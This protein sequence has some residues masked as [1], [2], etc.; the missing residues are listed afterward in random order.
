MGLSSVGWQRELQ[1]HLLL[2]TSSLTAAG[3]EAA[4]AEQELAAASDLNLQSNADREKSLRLRETG[5]ALRARADEDEVSAAAD[6]GRAV[7]LH[8]MAVS[9]EDQAAD[10]L[11]LAAVQDGIAKRSVA[12]GVEQSEG[13]MSKGMRAQVD[14][15]GVAL[16][17]VL[18]GVDVLCDVLGGATAVGLEAAAAGQSAEAA[19]DFAVASAAKEREGTEL[20]SAAEVQ[21]Q[22]TS[23]QLAADA[24]EEAGA[25]LTE[26]AASERAKAD[27]NE[28]RAEELMAKSA[29]ESEEATGAESRSTQ[30]AKD[31]ANDG[32]LAAQHGVLAI[33]Y[34]ILLGLTAGLAAVYFS[35]RLAYFLAVQ[36]TNSNLATCNATTNL[37]ATAGFWFWFASILVHSLVLLPITARVLGAH[38]KELSKGQYQQSFDLVEQDWKRM[39]G[40]LL[41]ISLVAMTLQLVMLH[42]GRYWTATRY[43]SW[44]WIAL[45]M[46]IAG[47]AALLLA[48]NSFTL[49]VWIRFSNLSSTDEWGSFWYIAQLPM[50]RFFLLLLG[51]GLTLALHHWLWLFSKAYLR[52]SANN[53]RGRAHQEISITCEST[54]LLLKANDG[55]P[56]TVV[57]SDGIKGVDTKVQSFRVWTTQHQFLLDTWFT[58]VLAVLLAGISTHTKV[59]HPFFP[60]ARQ[61]ALHFLLGWKWTILS[62][63]VMILVV[64]GIA[65]VIGRR[66][67]QREQHPPNLVILS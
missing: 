24:E 26:K 10:Y 61:A 30:D 35:L 33:G 38:P 13:A 44:T 21:G 16:C 14:E 66:Q 6:G 41:L 36:F 32:Q 27:I 53:I 2:M 37:Y 59:L 63:V 18:P 60:L 54:S 22:A 51:L 39:G 43:E 67:K 40:I 20:A 42:S 55:S 65:F 47:D 12:A 64:S 50:S 48:W 57:T 19:V 4:K 45:S 62:A 15:A 25:A 11:S 3:L 23:E 1:R 8:W 7:E 52:Q 29:G 5:E 17:Q 28:A 49:V 56:I 58:S 34:A 46:R 31:A 9:H